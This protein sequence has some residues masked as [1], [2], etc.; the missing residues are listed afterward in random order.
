MS[1]S[2]QIINKVTWKPE[3]N[4]QHV[5]VVLDCTVPE[6]IYMYIHPMQGNW[7]FLGVGGLKS[8]FF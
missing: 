6:N 4:Q 5:Q 3:A 1:P 8:Q 2:W 7:K